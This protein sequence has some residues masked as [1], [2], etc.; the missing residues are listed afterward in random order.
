[1]DADAAATRR[2]VQAT[3][4]S[5]NNAPCASSTS[6]DAAHASAMS[7]QVEEALRACG[8]DTLVPAAR[9]V[10]PRRTAETRARNGI[11]AYTSRQSTREGRHSAMKSTSAP[12]T[13]LPRRP[14]Q[15]ISCKCDHAQAPPVDRVRRCVFRGLVPFRPQLWEAAPRVC[16]HPALTPRRRVRACPPVGPRSRSSWRCCCRGA[17][18]RALLRA[19][20]VVG[21]VTRVARARRGLP[22]D[23][24]LPQCAARGMLR[25]RDDWRRAA[26]WCGM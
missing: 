10:A 17:R 15:R 3:S 25:A 11:P 22:T 2:R 24:S 23:R 9:E 6:G 8:R 14:E 21:A 1:M 20:R 26:H 5:S 19:R 13:R 4:G 18:H 16:S 7:A 12:H